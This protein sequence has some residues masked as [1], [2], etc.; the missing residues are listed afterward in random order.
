MGVC[1]S[2]LCSPSLSLLLS[3]VDDQINTPHV[4][5]NIFFD[6]KK[7]EWLLEQKK[8]FF[9]FVFFPPVVFDSTA[10]GPS[11]SS[12]FVPERGV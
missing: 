3:D 6:K 4:S 5:F 9:F 11:V 2:I 1:N 10:R 12:P 7:R 8:S